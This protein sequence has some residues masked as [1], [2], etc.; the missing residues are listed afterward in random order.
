MTEEDK[1]FRIWQEAEPLWRRLNPCDLARFDW[2]ARIGDAVAH[3][4]PE[5]ACCAGFRMI[6]A[7]LLGVALG[8][9]ACHLLGA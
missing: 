5:C 9:G 1:H 3:L 4:T 6:G 2:L 7:L 8:A